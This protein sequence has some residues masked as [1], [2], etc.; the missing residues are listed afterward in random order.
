MRDYEAVFI[1]DDRSLN[2]SLENFTNQ[3]VSQ[4][5]DMGGKVHSTESLGRKQFARPIKKQQAGTY[6]DFIISLDPDK[7][8]DF[9]ESYRLSD[10]VLRLKIFAYEEKPE[11]SA[12]SE[13]ASQPETSSGSPEQAAEA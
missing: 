1:V 5:Q 11:K 4:V 6:L 10:E 3:V 2:V 8:E 7:V 13:A 9:T 12:G